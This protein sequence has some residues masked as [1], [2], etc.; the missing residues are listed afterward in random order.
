M[1]RVGV[2]ALRTLVSVCGN[3]GETEMTAKAIATLLKAGPSAPIG[4]IRMERHA[5]VSANPA[6]AAQ[7]E[8]TFY[9]GL[10]RAS[11]PE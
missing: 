9:T 6:L 2:A 5:I 8:Q 11:L 4:K 3:R 7:V 10:K 1:P